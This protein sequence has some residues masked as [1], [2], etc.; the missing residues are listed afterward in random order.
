M[1]YLLY[2]LIFLFIFKFSLAQKLIKINGFTLKYPDYYVRVDLYNERQT[3]I[4]VD[5]RNENN[6][7]YVELMK[8]SDIK[9]LISKNIENLENLYEKKYKIIRNSVA[10]HKGLK[11]FILEYVFLQLSREYR[12][13]KYFIEVAQNDYVGLYCSSIS[14]DFDKVYSDFLVI[15]DSIKE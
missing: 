15:L 9:S 2:F 7:I 1:K 8:N 4:L 3:V 12:T 6:T 14:G 5:S 13:L 11:V 10:D